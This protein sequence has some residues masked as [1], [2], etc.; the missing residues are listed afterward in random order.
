MIGN[1]VISEVGCFYVC[2]TKEDRKTCAL[3]RISSWYHGMYKVVQIWPGLFVCKSGDIS[4]GHIWT[5]LYNIMRSHNK[6]IRY[7]Q[8]Q[9]F[10]SFSLCYNMA[11]QLWHKLSFIDAQ[12]D[13]C[14]EVLCQSHCRTSLIHQILRYHKRSTSSTLKFMNI[15]P[16]LEYLCF[17]T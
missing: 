14:M 4:P 5:T 15:S 7:N 2:C 1:V 3:Y 8:V 17:Y 6:W 13:R 11:G 10:T 9:L 12:N 16:F